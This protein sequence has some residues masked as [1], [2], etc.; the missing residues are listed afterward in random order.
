M[1]KEDSEPLPLP[2]PV[3]IRR[4][5]TASPELVQ[6]IRAEFEEIP[7]VCLTLYQAARLFE[8]PGD[9]CHRAMMTLVWAGTLQVTDD[10]RFTLRPAGH[11]RG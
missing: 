2:R 3:P 1:F 6:L 8:I 7:G 9:L 11:P 5:V 4:D 10:G